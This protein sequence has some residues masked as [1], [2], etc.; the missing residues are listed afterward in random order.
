MRLLIDK[1][2][3]SVEHLKCLDEA[4]REKNQ[5]YQRI[6]EILTSNEFNQIYSDIAREI[7]S[8]GLK[9]RD[10]TLMARQIILRDVILYISYI[11]SCRA[12]IPE[13]SGISGIDNI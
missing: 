10:N 3:I 6:E 2:A 13:I 9:P 4:F 5:E 7:Y 1:L 12:Q 8:G 11:S